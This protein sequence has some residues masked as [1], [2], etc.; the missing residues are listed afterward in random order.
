MI[1]PGTVYET[2]LTCYNCAETV[3]DTINIENLK[4]NIS[5]IQDLRE[6]EVNVSR[7]VK[8]NICTYLFYNCQQPSLLPNGS[9][10]LSDDLHQ[11]TALLVQ[12]LHESGFKGYCGYSQELCVHLGNRW[13]IYQRQIDNVFRT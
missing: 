8:K 13:Y 6:H 4:K 2:S 9:T 1:V 11:F 7:K 12:F 5:I 3:S 10:L